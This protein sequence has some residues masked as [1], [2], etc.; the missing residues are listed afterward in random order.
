[1]VNFSK[2]FSVK[3]KY[4]AMATVVFASIYVVGAYISRARK[5]SKEEDQGPQLTRS[6]SI[7]VLHGGQLAL[8]RLFEYHEARAD[9]S[10]VEVAE[11]ELKTHLAEQ[12]PDYKKL[13]SV[14]GKLEM[15]GKEAQAVEILKNATAKARNEGRNHEAYEYEMLLVEMLIYKGDFKEA[16]GR[17]CLRHVEISDARRPLFKA[18]IH[19]ML[20]CNE[21]EVTKYWREFND[22]KEEFQS[23]PCKKESMEECQLHKLSTNFNEFKK[24]V[25][26][27]KKDIIE[28]Q[29]KRNKK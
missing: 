3:T 19:I 15:S 17:E 20:E 21:N 1:M 25:H 14:I 13:Q 11:C 10:S 27:L 24:V 5:M 16:L 12:H 28:A 23:R 7:A 6:M 4:G 22:L 9:K 8:Q 29:A 2:S 26:M 18:I